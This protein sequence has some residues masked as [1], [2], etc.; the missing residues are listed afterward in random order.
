MPVCMCV[1]LS[2]CA[3]LDHFLG[4]GELNGKVV[5]GVSSRTERWDLVG[6]FTLKGTLFFPKWG[7]GGSPSREEEG[8]ACFQSS[9][10]MSPQE[11]G[12]SSLRA[13]LVGPLGLYLGDP[14]MILEV[15]VKEGCWGTSLVV[16]RSRICLPMQGT[17][18]QSLV[19]EDPTCQ[20]ATEPVCHN[21][22]ICA[23]EPWSH[24]YW[25]HRCSYWRLHALEPLLH[26][27]SHSKESLLTAVRE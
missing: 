8:E 5:N 26:K 22:Y 18:V 9:F 3:F 16:Q 24:N 25:G 4:F 19:G 7:C 6:I 15:L 10:L 27:I 14:V 21:Y 2:Q 17:W 23:L 20:E 12:A 13:S 11:C 1:S